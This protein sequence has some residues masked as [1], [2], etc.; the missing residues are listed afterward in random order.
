M[1]PKEIRDLKTEINTR[2]FYALGDIE[3]T[4]KKMK[5]A[6]ESIYDLFQIIFREEAELYFRVKDNKI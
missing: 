4:S 5:R 1:K 3:P 2:L 6:V